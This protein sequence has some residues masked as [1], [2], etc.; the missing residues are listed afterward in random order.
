MVERVRIDVASY[1]VSPLFIGNADIP[2]RSM[3]RGAQCVDYLLH[4]GC[5]GDQIVRVC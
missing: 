1:G 5:C 3:E 2:Y 4:C